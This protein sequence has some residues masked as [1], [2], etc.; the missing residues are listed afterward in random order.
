[1]ALIWLR[2]VLDKAHL[3]T[4]LTKIMNFSTQA[5]PH[6][7][8]QFGCFWEDFTP[9]CTLVPKINLCGFFKITLLLIYVDTM[10]IIEDRLNYFVLHALL[11]YL[12]TLLY[13]SNRVHI[14]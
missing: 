3:I 8:S 7:F 2:I 6:H 14:F 5:T 11:Q 4:I 1:M 9:F 13:Y 12:V 10:M